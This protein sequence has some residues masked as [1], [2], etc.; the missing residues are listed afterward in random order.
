MR[1][2]Q[3]AGE[4][5]LT[6]P[7]PGP[8]P[9]PGPRRRIRLLLLTA[10]GVFVADLLTKTWAVH[11]FAGGQ[12]LVLVPHLLDLVEIRNPGAAF[13]IA[14]GATIVFSL[15]ALVVIVMI[16]RTAAGL[17]SAGW[18]L[19]LGLLLGGAVGNLG[20]RLFRSPGVLRGA[21]VDWIYL[22]HW[23]VFNLAD[24]A[25]VVGGV[26]AVLLASG[27]RRPDGSRE[28]RG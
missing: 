9:R 20:D 8:G 13:G 24:S 18:A 22:H 14:G 1:D 5:S 2:V 28:P 23:P 26:L 16:A 3:A 19:A 7:N 21:V 25:I 15:V 12:R 10:A 4:P 11:H 27:G 6:E 17:R